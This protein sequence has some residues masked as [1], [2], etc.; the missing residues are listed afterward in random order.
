[1]PWTAFQLR[2]LRS[3]T[4]DNCTMPTDEI[5]SQLYARVKKERRAIR[6]AYLNA[7]ISGWPQKR[8]IP[9][10]RRQEGTLG[11]KKHTPIS[12]VKLATLSECDILTNFVLLDVKK[13]R[14]NFTETVFDVSFNSNKQACV[15]TMQGIARVMSASVQET[16]LCICDK[17]IN[18]VRNSLCDKERPEFDEKVKNGVLPQRLF[19]CVYDKDTEHGAGAHTDMSIQFRTLVLKLTGKDKSRECLRVHTSR[20]ASVDSPHESMEIR[21]SKGKCA[22]FP[23]CTWRSVDSVARKSTRV[24]FNIFF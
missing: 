16:L 17:A 15:L 5:I 19:F 21:L 1:M 8:V 12:E 20:I 13:E 14:V 3:Y 23:P 22:I 6:Q 18:L 24:T 4:D 7:K 11:I 9:R 10:E 2:L